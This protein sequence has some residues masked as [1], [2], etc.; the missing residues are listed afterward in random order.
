MKPRCLVVRFTNNVV[1]RIDFW[2]KEVNPKKTRHGKEAAMPGPVPARCTFPDDFVQDALDTVRR[3][4]AA[5]QVVQ[6]YRLVLLLHELPSLRNEEAADIVGLSPRQ[7]Q[8][9][10]S[11]WASGDFSIDDR[12]GRGRK[13]AF[14]PAG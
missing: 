13:P 11:R 12:S 7:V 14:S 2:Y 8:R 3:R 6:R 1:V 5:V 9:W 10:R 4:T